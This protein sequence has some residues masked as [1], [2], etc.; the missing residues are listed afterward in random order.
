MAMLNITVIN[1][2]LQAYREHESCITWLRSRIKTAPRTENLTKYKNELR[3]AKASKG[4][5]RKMLDQYYIH[6][7]TTEKLY[8][9]ANIQR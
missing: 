3:Q 2:L 7:I 9:D 4:V 8:H 5:T 6:G 1:D